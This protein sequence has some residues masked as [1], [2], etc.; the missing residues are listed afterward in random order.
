[1]SN[2]RVELII[3]CDTLDWGL[4]GKRRLFSTMFSNVSKL[5]S[6]FIFIFLRKLLF[7]VSKIEPWLYNK[8]P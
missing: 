6:F 5:T 3:F 2:M 1:M 7:H 4:M 8:I